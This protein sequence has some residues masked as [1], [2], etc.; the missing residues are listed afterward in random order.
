METRGKILVVDDEPEFKTALQ[1]FFEQQN[2]QVIVVSNK[3]QAKNMMR[4]E[5]PDLVILG[6]IMPRGDAF[7]YHQWL[8]RSS[9]FY[10]IP[11]LVIDA[12]PE[13]QLIK[14]WTRDEGL[15]LEAEDYFCK[16]VKPE[17]L[18]PFIEKL[19]DSTTN[20]IKVLIAD[21]HPVTREGIRTLL[22]LQKDIEVIGEAINGKEAIAKTLKLMPDV[23]LLD[24]VMPVMDGLEAT[25]AIG[26][27][28]KKTKIFR[29][30]MD[31]TAS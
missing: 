19:V 21:D 31:F 3:V 25:R 13:K 2:Y 26:K 30:V 15:R 1:V 18:L 12:T 27:L 9:H 10:D 29:N 22:N 11:L 20:K 17:S 6:T 7:I 23:V 14:G 8:K 16:P 28:C 24:I 4:Y 5:K